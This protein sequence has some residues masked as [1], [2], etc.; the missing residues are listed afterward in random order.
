[1]LG[2]EQ[3]AQDIQTPFLINDFF[4]SWMPKKYYIGQE[5]I[6]RASWLCNL[7]S[8]GY[9]NPPNNKRVKNKL[10]KVTY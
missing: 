2:I 7:Y 4:V 3:G 8:Y 6:R 1:M 10:V 5:E 9:T